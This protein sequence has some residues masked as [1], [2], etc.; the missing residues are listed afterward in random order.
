[1]TEGDKGSAVYGLIGG[2]DKNSPAA[3]DL[4]KQAGIPG[5]RYLDAG[6]AAVI[7]AR[8]ITSSSIHPRSISYASTG[9]LV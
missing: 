3:A 4:F 6:S 9:C 8:G 2:G 5:V 7:E 1:M